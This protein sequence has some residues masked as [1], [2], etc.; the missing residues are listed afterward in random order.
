MDWTCGQFSGGSYEHNDESSGS[1]QIGEFLDY[2][3]EL[4]DPD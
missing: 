2:L 4:K 1:V 3:H